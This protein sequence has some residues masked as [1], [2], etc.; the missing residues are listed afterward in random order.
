MKKNT[1]FDI[2]YSVRHV[3]AILC[4]ILG[5]FI[6]KHFTLLLYIKPY[7]SLST[8]ELWQMLW[9]SGSLFLRV[10]LIFNVFIKPLFIYF[11]VIF[12]FYCRKPSL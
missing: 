11:L 8:L 3:V 12:L 7:Q 4:S 6:I 1:W 5:F 10:I 9:H 2:F